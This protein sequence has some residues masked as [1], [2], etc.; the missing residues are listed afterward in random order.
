MIYESHAHGFAFWESLRQSPTLPPHRHF[1]PP[2][3]HCPQLSLPFQTDPRCDEV[4][5]RAKEMEITRS[6]VSERDRALLSGDYNAYHAQASRRI[7]TLRR[8]LGTATPKGRKYSPK[9]QVT[10]ANIS[11]N[12]ESVQLG[13][14]SPTPMTNIDID[15]FSFFC[16][17]QSGLGQ[18]QWQ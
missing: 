3:A 5:R 15:G 12:A 16:R 7:H 13:S 9:D 8:R 1:D 4:L 18:A 14:L 2:A 6:V 11:Q 17:V 10:A